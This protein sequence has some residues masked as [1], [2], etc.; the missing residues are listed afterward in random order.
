M[1]QITIWDRLRYLFDNTMSRGPIAL[2]AWLGLLSLL[3]I[4]ITTLIVAIFN[5]IPEGETLPTVAWSSLMHAIDAGTLSGRRLDDNTGLG[6]AGAILAT[7]G[8][9]FILSTLIGILN[10]GIEAKLEELRKGRSFVVEKQHT[11]ILGWSPQI[12]SVVSELVIANTSQAKSCIVILAEKDKVEME[13]EIREKVP[14]TGKTRIVCRTGSPIDQGDLQ[15]VNP[16]DAKS[17]VILP[18][19]AENPDSHVIKT[20]LALTNN[21]QRRTQPYHIISELREASNLQVAKMIA[22]DE[23]QLLLASDFISRITV[24]TCRQSGLSVV[25]TELLDFG[26]DEIYFKQDTALVGKMFSDALFAYETSSVIGI[27]NPKTG[28]RIN[29]PLATRLGTEDHLIFIAEDD[30]TI[31]AS[32]RSSYP[33]Q[34]DLIQQLPPAPPKPERTLILGWNERAPQIINELDQ[35]VTSGSQLTVVT[36]TEA[37]ESI[38]AEECD[39][40]NQ[41]I[42]FVLGDTTDRTLLDALQVATYDHAILLSYSDELDI[43]EADALTLIT[44]LHLRDIRGKSG[45]MFPVVSEMLDVRNRE[46]AK[47][48]HADDFIVS[49]K[50]V[51]LLLTQVSENKDL[52]AVFDDLF[53]PE[54]A[55]IYLKPAANYVK[56]GTKVNFYTVLESARQRDEIAIGYR[57]QANADSPDKQYGVRLNPPKSQEITLS[58]ND[59]VIVVSN[60]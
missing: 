13:D 46:L 52:M 39:P 57:L 35:Y 22:K 30:S 3:L 26:G 27:Y 54:G 50:L 23:A 11:I 10:S 8:G 31:T 18:G 19:E 60:N 43:Q 25:Y 49:D 32:T 7:L 56:L 47:T 1:R 6:V 34:A 42:Q 20:I 48:T 45:R 53:D 5:G 58:S 17:I 40:Q 38:I 14:N 36:H 28:A 15:I 16:D 55:E 44:L 21:P 9:I 41:T 2:I 37:A 4:I 59:F 33:I 24:Q 51:S 29:P 12:F